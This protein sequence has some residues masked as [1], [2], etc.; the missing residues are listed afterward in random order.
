[1]EF[2][3]LFVICYLYFGILRLLSPIEEIKN[4]LDIVEVVSGYIKLQKAGRNFRANC[5]FH[6]E[7]TPSLMISPERQIWHCFGCGKGGDIFGF[8]KEI[9][10]LEFVETLRLLAQRAGVILKKQD[11]KIKDEKE[12]LTQICALSAKFFSKQLEEGKTGGKIKKYLLER[13]INQDSINNWQLGFA[14]DDWHALSKFLK[15]RGYNDEEIIKSGLVVEKM[16]NDYRL[17]SAAKNTNAV[18]RSPLANNYYDRFRD[19]IIFPIFDINEQPVG[20]A[21]RVAP[22]QKEDTAK[23]VNTPQT[24]IYDK[25]RI[26]YGLD[27]AKIEIRAKNYC[28][29]VEGNTDVI[30]SHQAGASNTVA[31]SGTALTLDHL[32]IIKRYTDNLFLAFDLDAAGDL[33]TKRAI[34]LAVSQGFN[35]KI[36]YPK[37]NLPNEKLDPADIIKKNPK[38][39]INA[40]ENAQGVVEFYFASV[41]G[42][43]DAGKV[44]GKKEIAKKILPLL[45]I[46]P[47][48]IEQAYWMQELAEKLSVP[49][50]SLI[51]AI[52]EIKPVGLS[53]QR[54]NNPG[55]DRA[56]AAKPRRLALEEEL[57]AMILSSEDIKSRLLDLEAAIKYAGLET[58]FLNSD[59]MKMMLNLKEFAAAIKDDG[60][61]DALAWQSQLPAELK[62]IA[63]QIV[64]QWEVMHPDGRDLDKKITACL[65]EM[66]KET[67]KKE[68][69]ALQ[70]MIKSAEEKNDKKDLEERVKEY[71]KTA[72][73]GL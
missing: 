23:Y 33:A 60:L 38:D 11:P 48:K 26:L 37:K 14:P 40:I 9:E 30:M 53:A 21:G 16:A 70:K 68:M 63:N 15:D 32:K 2:D 6:H 49:E 29:V 47:D 43:H 52:K 36:I 67:A 25:G 27:K 73:K 17:P 54:G 10:G 3:N 13:G 65:N 72:K 31:S 12:R 42:A 61:I 7:K 1:L 46:I 35:I 8:V 57:L 62:D 19:R 5:P 50:K 66:K 4:R 56:K 18:V 34:D 55:K 45:K 71:I 58:L 44:S 20:F 28:V 41:F 51:E 59:L 69:A 64:F 24:P 22:G 39:W